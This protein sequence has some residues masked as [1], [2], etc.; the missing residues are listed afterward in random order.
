MTISKKIPESIPKH[1]KVAED[2]KS[3]KLNSYRPS[4]TCA[5]LEEAKIIL[6]NRYEK[7][8]FD[9]STIRKFDKYWF[10][11]SF[12]GKGPHG[13]EQVLCNWPYINGVSTEAEA[14]KKIRKDVDRILKENRRK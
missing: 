7:R 10:T 3:K 1:H 13:V 9:I 2:N 12:K 14:Q 5:T 11:V 8:G 6:R 4:P